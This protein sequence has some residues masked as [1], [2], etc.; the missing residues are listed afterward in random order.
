[1]PR[2]RN[3]ALDLLDGFGRVCRFHH[4]D[5]LDQDSGPFRGQPAGTRQSCL[6]LSGDHLHG[7]VFLDPDFSI[8][9]WVRLM[10][11][12][13]LLRHGTIN[14]GARETIFMN[15]LSR[16]SRATGPNT[17]VPPARPFVDQHKRHSYQT[18]I[19]AVFTA[20]LFA[21]PNHYTAH[22]LPFL[23]AESGA[24]SFTLA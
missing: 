17:R 5:A 11:V 19:G 9:P 13:N 6:Y 2:A 18:D 20:G 7:V 8:Q 10:T 14:S 16:S 22:N 1:M 24:A 15:F 4:P 21:H 3:A 23:M 12:G